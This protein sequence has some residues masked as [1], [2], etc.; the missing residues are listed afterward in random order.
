MFTKKNELETLNL[1]IDSYGFCVPTNRLSLSQLAIARGQKKDKYLVGL[2]LKEMAVPDFNQ[3]S[4]SMSIEAGYNTLRRGNITPNDVDCVIVGTET[5]AYAVKPDASAVLGALGINSNCHIFDIDSACSAMTEGVLSALG[6]INLG[7]INNALVIGSDIAKYDLWSPGEPTQGAGAIGVFIKE[8]PRIARFVSKNGRL[9]SAKFAENTHDFLRLNGKETATVFGDYSEECYLRAQKVVFNRLCKLLEIPFNS[10]DL[11]ARH[12]PFSKLPIKAFADI[13]I[14][15]WIHPD[16]GERLEDFLQ[17]PIDTA[18][19]TEHIIKG[20]SYLHSNIISL[21][22]DKGFS[23]EDI[24]HINS[25]MK[26]RVDKKIKSGLTIPRMF[27]NMYSASVWAE[28]CYTLETAAKPNDLV[29]VGSY[30][31]GANCIGLALKLNESMNSLNK[32]SPSISENIT[33]KREI[34]VSQYEELRRGTNP[35]SNEIHWGAI[36]PKEG[37]E[38]TGLELYLCTQCGM[39]LPK[40]KELRYCPREHKKDSESNIPEVSSV[41]FPEQAIFV[42][43]DNPI[44]LNPGLTMANYK[45]VQIQGNPKPGDELKMSVRK[46]T[47]EDGIMLWYPIYI[48]PQNK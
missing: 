47:F 15:H 18:I 16:N 27:G 48:K 46:H 30:G 6:M 32:I 13:H 3:D 22:Q 5:K 9:A 21:L 42:S 38:N 37:S 24:H 2:G 17:T 33:E 14:C 43:N 40:T 20:W 41:F 26:I 23:D 35:F 31:S 1:G 28:F 10:F 45:L 25:A 7:M 36:K 44:P 29:Y 4:T 39:A 11:E 19:P 8:N 12:A 34:T